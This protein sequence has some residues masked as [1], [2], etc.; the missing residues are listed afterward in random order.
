MDIRFGDY[1]DYGGIKGR[2]ERRPDGV[3]VVTPDGKEVLVEGGFSGK[4]LKDLGLKKIEEP[5][6]GEPKGGEPK[7]EPQPETEVEQGVAEVKAPDVKFNFEENTVT[8]DGKK[9]TYDGVGVDKDG[10]T[11]S[12]RVIDENGNVRHLRNEEVVFEIELQKETAE[13]G[14][15]EKSEVEAA[16]KELNIKEQKNEKETRGTPEKQQ[17]VVEKLQPA[18]QAKAVEENK[19]E[20]KQEQ[21]KTQDDA[22]Q[23]Q[24]TKGVDVRQQAADGE[25]VGERNAKGQEITDKGEAEKIK[26]QIAEENAK[27]EWQKEQ[28]AIDNDSSLS[29]EEKEKK[30]IESTAK[31]LDDKYFEDKRVGK[32]KQL[33]L[34]D[35]IPKE[36]VDN[37]STN[38][39]YRVSKMDENLVSK[40][41]KEAQEN[42]K[43][44]NDIFKE[45]NR[46]DVISEAY[47]KA[48]ADGSNPELV[49]AV[50]EL[51][52][53][54]KESTELEKQQAK[55]QKE[56]PQK[57][58]GSK[59]ISNLKRQRTIKTNAVRE[60]I[61]GLKQELDNIK[62]TKR[63]AKKIADIQDQ[64]AAKEKEY[65]GLIEEY[66][67]MKLIVTGKQIG[68]AHV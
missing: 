20:Q 11:T 26:K 36:Q 29:E 2:V 1:V 24:K 30:K 35:L 62:P 41:S 15:I 63:N 25:A 9:Y 43:K 10:N 23:E 19:G 12:I 47:H 42:I 56:T 38:G 58:V 49:K 60:K 57:P 5:K 50:E 14:M 37:P 39:F 32:Q 67:N 13:L 6:G 46:E 54:P 7:T 4:R 55:Q 22:V 3:V 52:G 40:Q 31:A 68:R 28:E 45:K 48:K 53:K 51:L 16:A 27:S 44:L 21:L 17:G 59:E 61:A 33:E 64:I 34:I 66:D 8:V 65:A 18:E